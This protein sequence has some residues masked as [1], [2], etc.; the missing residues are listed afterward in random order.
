MKKLG[1]MCLIVALLALP[2]SALAMEKMSGQDLGDVTGQAGVSI[3]FEGDS[4]TTISFSQVAWGDPDG[5]T[6]VTSA[7]CGNGP[8]WIILDGEGSSSVVIQQIIADGEVLE[9]DIGTTTATCDIDGDGSTGTGVQLPNAKT[10]IAVGLPNMT[11]SITTP[12]TLVV[13]LGS[14]SQ[15]ITGTLGLLNLKN[16][17][18]SVTQPNKLYIW[19]H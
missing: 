4:I 16:L 9:L 2:I 10:F 17:D 1:L 11:V 7:T 18:I 15:A 13:G 5:M 6:T 8:G 3:G 12:D 19:A 14:T